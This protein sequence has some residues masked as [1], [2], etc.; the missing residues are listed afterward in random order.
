MKA[1][2]YYGKED[3]RVEDIAKPKPEKGGL[4]VK[5]EACAICG[6]DLK[7]Y[8]SGNPR[9]KPPQTIGH[10]FVGEIVER[11]ADTKN[12]AVGDRVTM[13]TSISWGNSRF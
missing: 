2:R 5:V 9:I 12:F 7:A 4:L 10:E 6:T 11:G 8:F 1:V 13:A 3:L